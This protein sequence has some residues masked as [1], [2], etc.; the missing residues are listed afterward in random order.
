MRLALPSV[1][2]L[3]ASVA[4]AALFALPAAAAPGTGSSAAPTP[5]ATSAPAAPGPAAHV[6]DQKLG[7]AATAM[8]HVMTLRKSYEQKLDKAT[9]QDKPRIANEGEKALKK[10]VTDQGLSVDEYNSIIMEARN[11]PALR[12][13]LLAHVKTQP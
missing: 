7:Q 11:D 5:P 8:E 13:K 10:A 1:T 9:P 12:Q 4:A 2:T 3:A 6:S